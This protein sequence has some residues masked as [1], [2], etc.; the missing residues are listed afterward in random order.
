MKNKIV[1]FIIL[2]ILC[3]ELNFSQSAS[4]QQ[5]TET[6]TYTFFDFEDGKHQGAWVSAEGIKADVQT[7]T[8]TVKS[9]TRACR[10]SWDFTNSEEGIVCFGLECPTNG[11]IESISFWL[12]ANSSL[13]GKSYSIWTKDTNGELYLANFTIEKAGWQHIKTKV[14]KS[15][16]WKAGDENEKQDPPMSIASLTVGYDKD[17][18]KDYIII[19]DVEA[20]VSLV[21][22]E[23]KTEEAETK[24]IDESDLETSEVWINAEDFENTEGVGTYT[25]GSK[26]H[27]SWA[28][29]ETENVH[30]G[31]K[32]ANLR[33]KFDSERGGY[34]VYVIGYK[35]PGKIKEIEF[36]AYAD[37][38]SL[39]T[40]ISSWIPDE[41]DEMYCA[42]TVI[43]KLG[44]NKYNM[45]VSDISPW[46]SGDGNSIKDGNMTFRSILV[47][48]VSPALTGNI[49][50]D[51]ISC[52]VEAP[53]TH[54]IIPSMTAEKDDYTKFWEKKGNLIIQTENTSEQ[55]VKDMSYEL[56]IKDMNTEKTVSTKKIKP[57]AIKPGDK[58]SKKVFIELPFGY[59][60]ANLKQYIGKRLISQQTYPLTLLNGK[61]NF[62]MGPAMNSYLTK[63]GYFGGVC[64]GPDMEF[65]NNIGAKW[66]RYT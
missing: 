16:P 49:L 47:E 61:C 50:I 15:I 10:M 17:H 38:N 64:T 54:F 30:S 19:D 63:A 25:E 46:K 5:N 66:N 44:W 32:S 6:E 4:A 41:N 57:F 58:I 42:A 20:E 31:K 55:S 37:E 51:D 56:I 1:I 36:W 22:P 60:E 13:T 43:D 8:E 34:S 29:L 14:S 52:L 11:I 62:N 33:W 28:N 45:K 35:S 53:Y 12:Y 18:L 24:V 21:M 39:G 65:L 27:Q 7:E 23:E 9:G 26:N 40:K 3:L 2:F 59:Y 48:A